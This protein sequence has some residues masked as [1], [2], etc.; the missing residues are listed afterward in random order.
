MPEREHL[1]R[2]TNVWVS[3]PIYFITVCIAGRRKILAAPASA[4]LLIESWNA[5]PE[6]HGWVIGRY[7]IMPDHVHFFARPQPEGKTLSAFIRDWKKWTTKIPVEASPH[8]GQVWQSEFFDH[9]L[10]SPDSYAEKWNYVR[11]NP[12][13]AGLSR[14]PKPGLLPVRV[15]T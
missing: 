15:R 12:V 1:R 5:T 11:E 14:Q 6:K 4:K 7:V 13:R 8:A 2:L 10:R 3:S 9:I